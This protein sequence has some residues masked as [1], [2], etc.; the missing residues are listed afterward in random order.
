MKWDN[1]T[2]YEKEKFHNVLRAD[3]FSSTDGGDSF[4]MKSQGKI[5]SHAPAKS[6]DN[7]WTLVQRKWH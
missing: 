2:V 3:G 7:G 1:F 5:P 4:S 6:D